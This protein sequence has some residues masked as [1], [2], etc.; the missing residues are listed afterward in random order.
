MRSTVRPAD[1]LVSPEI[2]A[3]EKAARMPC[4]GCVPLLSALAPCSRE[5]HYGPVGFLGVGV[6]LI[7]VILVLVAPLHNSTCRMLGLLRPDKVPVQ[8]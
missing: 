5:G 2:A 6:A 8:A 4:K 3:V 7:V 1:A